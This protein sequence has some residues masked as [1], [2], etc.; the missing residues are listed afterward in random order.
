MLWR[1]VSHRSSQRA[2][3]RQVG[4]GEQADRLFP[5]AQSQHRGPERQEP[6]RRRLQGVP[7]DQTLRR[8]MHRQSHGALEGLAQDGSQLVPGGALSGG[9]HSPEP[10]AVSGSPFLRTRGEMTCQTSTGFPL[11]CQQEQAWRRLL[12]QGLRRATCRVDLYGAVDPARLRN[13]V[14]CVVERYEILRTTIAC[15]PK[16]GVWSQQIQESSFLWE[17][18]DLRRMGPSLQ[19]RWL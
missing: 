6:V 18:E 12:K 3:L 17:H 4:Q 11:S 5:R 9:A 14:R 10:G 7:G 8:R 19:A 16:S 2:D 15:H 1:K 13:A